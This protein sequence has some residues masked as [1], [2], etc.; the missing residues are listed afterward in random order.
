ME[1]GGEGVKYRGGKI[2]GRGSE[3]GSLKGGAFDKDLT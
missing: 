3:M 2:L 1:E